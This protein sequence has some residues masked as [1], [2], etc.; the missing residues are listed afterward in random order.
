MAKGGDSAGVALAQESTE[1]LSCAGMWPGAGGRSQPS[2]EKPFH[3]CF[4]LSS[5]QVI[6]IRACRAGRTYI[7]IAKRACGAGG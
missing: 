3:G 5:V 6:R 2:L 1:L 4:D 7:D